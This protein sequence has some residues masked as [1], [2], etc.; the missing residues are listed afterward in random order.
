M[1]RKTLT[2]LAVLVGTCLILSGCVGV[3]LAGA[4]GGAGGYRW[5]NGK[6]SFTTSHSIGECRAATVS[7]FEDLNL[8]VTS[9]VGD[10]V[11]G[12]IKG[13]TAFGDP[14]TVDLEPQAWNITKFDVRIGFW[15]NGEKEARLADAIK[16]HLH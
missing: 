13:Q 16:R 6:L 10:K 8:V 12:K 14:V 4:A 15:G 7:A 3:V 9:N 5:A 1:N 11:A 2:L